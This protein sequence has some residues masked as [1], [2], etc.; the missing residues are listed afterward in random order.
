MSLPQIS[1]HF[2]DIFQRREENSHAANYIL[3]LCINTLHSLQIFPK[4]PFILCIPAFILLPSSLLL[5]LALPQSPLVAI[6]LFP[7]PCETLSIGL[8]QGLEY[9]SDN[10]DRVLCVDVCVSALSGADLGEKVV[11]ACSSFLDFGDIW[12]AGYWLGGA[13]VRAEWSLSVL[14]H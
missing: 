2:P 6:V 9:R 10:V 13:S 3:S 1:S 14:R 5:N 11:A 12:A 7:P 4:F 8:V